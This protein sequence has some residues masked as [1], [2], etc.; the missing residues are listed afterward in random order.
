MEN[1]NNND[2]QIN[3]ELTEDVASGIYSNLAIITHSPGEF[4]SDFIQLMPGVPKGKVKSRIIMTPQNAK[5]F[6]K[7]L[8]ENIQKYEQ[9]FGVIQEVEPHNGVA[10]MNF[11]TPTT[12]A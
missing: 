11:G 12:E 5:R 3:I 2:N 10:R 7:A 8:A 9:T 6:M 1:N 4:V